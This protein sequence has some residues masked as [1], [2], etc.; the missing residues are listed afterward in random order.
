MNIPTCPRNALFVALLTVA[1]GAPAQEPQE[2]KALSGAELLKSC[3]ASASPE[4]EQ[5]CMRFIVGLVQTVD[6]LQQANPTQRLF[7][8]DPQRVGPEEVRDKAVAWLKSH[9]SRLEEEAY[10]L[11]SEALNQAY[12]CEG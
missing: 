6:T 7:C 2:E 11:V 9:E 10:V 4:D 3:T 1:A 8:I 12:P 5:F